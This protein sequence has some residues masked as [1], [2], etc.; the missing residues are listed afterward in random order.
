MNIAAQRASQLHSCWRECPSHHP[1]G[2]FSG[3]FSRF[4][5]CSGRPGFLSCNWLLSLSTGPVIWLDGAPAMVAAFQ[6]LNFTELQAA[7]LLP[8]GVP[9]DPCTWSQ[10][11]QLSQSLC[12]V[13]PLPRQ[14]NM[15]IIIKGLGLVDVSPQKCVF[16]DGL[17]R[18]L[19]GIPVYY[20]HQMAPWGDSMC[21]HAA[22]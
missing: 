5:L 8:A 3:D 19:T 13:M 10:P 20:Q 1:A 12:L 15:E 2:D 11:P 9:W 21:P 17:N 4:S 14:L 16:G 22:W 7:S 6:S 18:V